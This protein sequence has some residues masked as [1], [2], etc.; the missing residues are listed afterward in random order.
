MDSSYSTP[1]PYVRV[2]TR[3]WTDFV[4]TRINPAFH[5]FL[6]FRPAQSSPTIDNVR[7]DFL[8]TLRQFAEA[9]EEEGP[10]FL[11]EEL[12]LVDFVMAP[13]AVRLWIFDRW[14]GGRSISNH[15]NSVDA[16]AWYKL[17]RLVAAIQDHKSIKE[18]TS[19]KERYI[20]IYK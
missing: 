8:K 10:F 4:G 17:R 16:D 18:T 12:F 1:D 5:R 11:G 6:Q 2:R 9:I 14:K 19:D 13:W 15:S 3:I 7:S 20:P